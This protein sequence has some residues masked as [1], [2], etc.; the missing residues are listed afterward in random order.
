MSSNID[1]KALWNKEQSG[2]PD[3]KEIFAKAEKLNRKTRNNIWRS[4]IILS[5]TAIFII[6]IWWY[7]QPEMI[8]T[9]IG[10]VMIVLAIASLVTIN[11]RIS[12][13]LAKADVEMDSQQYLEQMIAIKQKQEFVN[14]TVYSVYYLV[15]SVGIGLYMIE[16][17]GRG[18]LTFKLSAYGLT[19]AWTAFAWFY[20]RPKSIQ[21]QRKAINEVIEKLE[22]VNGQ[23]GGE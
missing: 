17:A 4:N 5:L 3:V 15:L 12:P 6:W 7:Y 21:K 2:V 22:E 14:R 13:L 11:Q 1:F 23:L 18:S 16:Y 19:Y 9:K 20:I 10:I 8:T